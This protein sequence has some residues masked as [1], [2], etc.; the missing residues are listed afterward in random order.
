MLKKINFTAQ[1]G[2]KV[3]LVGRTGAGKST[4]S[5]A[6]SRIV[7][8]CG[9]SIEIDGVDISM[10]DLQVLRQKVTVIPQ[11][12]V[13]FTGSLRY[14]IDP[15]NKVSDE[16]I[17][18]LLEMA[19]L[20]YL[21]KREPEKDENEIIVP[22]TEQKEDDSSSSEN[23]AE[24][25]VLTKEEQ[26][27]QKLLQK[28]KDEL[29][30]QERLERLEE[31]GRG[32]YMKISEGGLNLSVGEKQLICICRAILRQNKIVVLD[33]ATANID[34]ITEHWIQKV[35]ADNFANSTVIT[36]AHRLNTIIKSDKIM[37]LENGTVAEFGSPA[38]LSA[39]PSSKFALL[40]R[41]IRREKT[42]TTSTSSE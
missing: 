2:E 41:D 33:E 8:L 24:K 39:D 18:E 35:L 31:E 3:G 15:F 7:E 42:S 36:I 37:V 23:E 12:P 4:I 38:S 30:S 28:T 11:D 16:K 40:L 34:V 21:I 10:I 26:R 13:L 32:I 1:P 14:N 22:E 5:N 20:D 25:F 29:T 17:K 9:G 27:L 19:G 6:L